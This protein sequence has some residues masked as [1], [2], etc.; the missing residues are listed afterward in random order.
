ML[1]DIVSLAHHPYLWAQKLNHNV[2]FWFQ[3]LNHNV[4]FWDQK[5]IK[6]EN[7]LFEWIFLVSIVQTT[8]S[9]GYWGNH[10][11]NFCSQKLNQ[12]SADPFSLFLTPE[13]VTKSRFLGPAKLL[14]PETDIMV[15]FLAPE[16]V[17]MGERNFMCEA[18]RCNPT[19][20]YLERRI[21]FHQQRQ[22]L[23]AIEF[24]ETNLDSMAPVC[25][26]PHEEAE[27]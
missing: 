22:V 5:L 16:I 12:K 9:I 26:G 6:W 13:T 1:P 27:D 17:I 2:I 20:T 11:D 4:S 23:V 25:P 18:S 15:Q 24:L 19:C 14:E 10:D 3:K 7:F 8:F 21:L